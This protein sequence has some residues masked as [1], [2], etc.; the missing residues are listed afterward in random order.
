MDVEIQV[1]GRD[2]EVIRVCPSFKKDICEVAG[3]EPARILCA[4]TDFCLTKEWEKC[5]VYLAQYFVQTGK[6]SE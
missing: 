2:K 1:D 3:I 4:D 5:R 6:A